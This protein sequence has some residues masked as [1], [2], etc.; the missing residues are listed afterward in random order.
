M[1]AVATAL[2]LIAGAAVVLWYGN[3]LNSWVLGGLIGG[4]AALLL[5]IPISLTLF[6]YLSRRHDEQLQ[7]DEQEEISMAQEEYEYASSQ[8]PSRVGKRAY[9]VESYILTDEASEE[10][11]QEEYARRAQRS[12]PAPTSQR[13][14]LAN[15]GQEGRASERLPV[16]RG[17]YLP[18]PRPQQAKPRG[19]ETAVLRATTRKMNYP[20]FPG[21]EPGSTLSQHRSEALRAARLEAAQ[22]R[23]DDVEVFPTN[24]PKRGLSVRPDQTLTDQ[25][26]HGTSQR[27]SRQLPQQT[28]NQ[29]RS[30]RVVDA[31]PSQQ[32]APRPLPAEGES[33][34]SPR[35]SDPQTDYLRNHLPQT[36]PLRRSAQTG[37]TAHHRQGGE[38][39]VDSA[40]T[41]GNLNKPLVRRA[42]YLYADD[43]LRQQLAQQIADT[44][45]VRRSSRHEPILN[46]DDNDL[47]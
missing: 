38:R 5:S 28:A 24:N 41:T 22:Q 47:L 26:R 39:S 20:G 12:L 36:A 11:W 13:R 10:A 27:P 4:L 29:Q 7:A 2:V 32:G 30:R 25:G 21:Y 15:Q 40:T 37:Q 44:P 34:A 35:R 46:D 33:T 3:T 6:S 19:K 31:S 14:A 9:Q 1:K 16:P 18:V 42:P 8:M 45:A 17:A 23:E 43:P